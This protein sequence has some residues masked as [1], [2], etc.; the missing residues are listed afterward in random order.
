MRRALVVLLSAG[1]L[2]VAPLATAEEVGASGVAPPPALLGQGAPAVYPPGSAPLGIS[3]ARWAAQWSQWAFGTPTPQN[4]LA[5]LANCNVGQR[6]PAFF[7]PA[8]S[9]PNATTT[10]TVRA[11]EPLLLFPGG[12]IVHPR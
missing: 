11:G 12:T 2:T 10:C 5:D 8:P 1:F 9:G 3:Y 6:A 4:P 7:L